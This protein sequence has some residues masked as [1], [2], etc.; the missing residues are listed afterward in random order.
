MSLDLAP[1]LSPPS[2]PSL[3]STM[4]AQMTGSEILKMAADIRELE[5]KGEKIC[6]LTIGDF[7]PSEFPVPRRLLALIEEALHE[8]HTNYPPSD[9]VPEL[10]RGIQALYEDV[11]GLSYPLSGV[12]VAGGARPII[13]GFFRAVLEPG[14]TLLYP[15]PSWNNNHYAHLTDVKKIEVRTRPED[16]FMP[17][18]SELAPHVGKAR[19]LALCSPLNPSGTMMSKE[20]LAPVARLVVEENRRRKAEGRKPLLVLFD[21]IY[22]PLTHGP[23]HVTPVELEPELANVTVFVDGISKALAATGVRVGWGVGAPAIISRMRDL[24]GHVGAWAPKPEQVATARFLAEPGA[25][26][27]EARLI[28]EKAKTRLDLLYGA[29]ERMRANGLP[30]EAIAPQGAIYLSVRFGLEGAFQTTEDV[31][32]V[33]LSEAGFAVVP[34]RA[35]GFENEDGWCRLSVGAVSLEAIEKALPRVEAALVKAYRK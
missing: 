31:R 5:A 35:F 21:Q 28:G 18:V 15:V 25:F 23:R 19:V 22:W 3:V 17:S 2:D 29:F 33:L 6:N 24:L 12:V 30:V 13:Y 1:Y 20:Q 16:A 7:R 14:D 26:E 10:R 11:L 27:R 34:F 4:A 32:R 8:G 9:G